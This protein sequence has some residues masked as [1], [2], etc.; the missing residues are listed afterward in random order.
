[1]P[2]LPYPAIDADGHVRERDHELRDYLPAPYRDMDWLQTFPFFPTLDGWP[3]AT[4]SPGKRDDPDANS[5]L[6]FLD[7]CGLERTYLYPTAGLG[8]GLI[9]DKSWA[10]ALASAYNNW[11]HDRYMRV[12][13]RLIGVALLPIH[14]VP[15]AVRELRRVVVELGM[16]AALLPAANV[17][18]KSFGHPDFR[19]L[20]E[21]AE[22]LGCALAVHGAPSKGLGFDH[23]DTFIKTHTLEHPFS[24]LIQLTSM[25]FDGLF[26]LFPRL[27]VAFLEC[28][29]G[30]VPYMMDRLDEEYE[31]RGQRDAPLLKRLPSEYLRAGNIYVSCE[32]EER[33][34]PYVLELLGTQQ[35]FFASDYPHEREH[36]EYLHDIPEFLARADLNE[37]AKRGILRDNALA[38]YG[39][40]ERVTAGAV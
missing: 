40:A 8:F 38:F 36:A 17:L 33:T 28:G 20:F 25:M 32:V 4:T 35:V 13:P 11:L 27:R 9:Q 6:A 10:I 29:A 16:P 14:D 21:E 18:G 19:P 22:R 39:A 30:W 5:W 26:E 24:V 15:E 23:F 1:M 12:S 3:R 7:E 34:L 2:G 31:R 37:D